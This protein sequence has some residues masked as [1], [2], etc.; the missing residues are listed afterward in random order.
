MEGTTPERHEPHDPYQQQP[1]GIPLPLDGP[2]PHLGVGRDYPAQ[3]RQPQEPKGPLIPVP[4]NRRGQPDSSEQTPLSD[5]APDDA[6]AMPESVSAAQD[7]ANLEY[8]RTF[9]VANTSP[10]RSGEQSEVLLRAIGHVTLGREFNPD[11]GATFERHSNLRPLPPFPDAVL[12]RMGILRGD[13]VNT[14]YFCRVRRC[15]PDYAPNQPDRDG[16][17]GSVQFV[18]TEQTLPAKDWNVHGDFAE[19][20]VIYSV[21]EDASGNHFVERVFHSALPMREQDY[22]GPTAENG[23]P[24][25]IAIRQAREAELED[26]RRFG[27]L[28]P[29][30]E[31]IAAV[32]AYVR[33]LGETTEY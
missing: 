32:D 18:R 16:L 10:E 22:P 7:R 4:E 25:V 24:D 14:D 6:D 9:F 23:K 19:S 12:A 3:T 13:T 17:L 31:E 29:S 26:A 11:H 1:G 21:T 15:S 33:A 5:S 8:Y 28:T 27:L 20:Q 2:V 30:L